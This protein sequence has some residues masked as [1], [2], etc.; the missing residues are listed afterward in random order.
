MA[1]A[2]VAP[3]LPVQQMPATAKKSSRSKR[4]HVVSSRPAS[5]LSSPA[6]WRRDLRRVPRALSRRH[7][8]ILD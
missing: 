8:R 1:T 7:R 4:I 2:A 6:H 5:S 3:Q